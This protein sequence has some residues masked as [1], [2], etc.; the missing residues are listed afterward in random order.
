VNAF[1]QAFK[2]WPADIL[3][4]VVTNLST[5]AILFLIALLNG[6]FY[7]LVFP[8]DVIREYPLICRAEPYLT[9]SGE[10]AVDFF[11]INRYDDDFTREKL[12]TFLKSQ[13]R[14]SSTSPSPEIQLDFTQGFGRIASATEDGHFNSGKGEL[15]VSANERRVTIDVQQIAAR[16]L[17]KV[18][19]IVKDVA[20]KP[21][22]R[23]T[24]AAVPLNFRPYL[25]ACYSRK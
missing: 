12:V 21:I 7:N 17:M 11:I 22:N 3:R 16:A 24:G 1:R 6:P 5:A 19:I 15:R 18:V 25:D 9:D 10:F 13:T 20:G 14:D 8:G 23:M 4:P 2:N